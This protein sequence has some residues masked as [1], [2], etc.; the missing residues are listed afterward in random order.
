MRLY[1][2]DID[3]FD[4]KERSVIRLFCKDSKG[5]TVVALDYDFLPYF[6]VVPKKGKENKLA[7]MIRDIKSIRVH[8]IKAVSKKVDNDQKLLKASCFLASDVYK[9]RDIVKTWD[10]LVEGFFEYSISFYK[11][12]LIDKQIEGWIDVEGKKIDGKYDVD[13]TILLSKI[14]SVESAAKPKISMM[15]FDTEVVEDKGEQKLVMISLK[16]DD[17]EKVL[18]YGKAKSN[19][20]MEVLQSEESML[21]RFVEIVKEKNPDVLFGYNSDEFDFQVLRNSANKNPKMKLMLSRDNSRM[22]FSRRARI[23]TAKLTGRVHIDLFQFIRTVLSPQ[24]QT[25]VLTLDAV[26]S[27]ILSD[28]KMEM[29]YVDIEKTWKENAD[30]KKLASYCLKDS[31]LTLRLGKF[32][33]PQILQLARISGQSIFDASRMTYS[34]LVE[35]YLSKKAFAENMVIPNN[36]RW[37]EVQERRNF[38]PYIGGFV[39]EPTAGLHDNITVL[40]FRSLYPSVI[41]TFNISPETLNC[42][43]CKKSGF[44][45]P[46]RNYWFCK[47]RKGFVSSVIRELIEKR[48]RI[49]SS[50]NGNEISG[51]NNRQFAIKTI[52]NATYGY[53]GFAGSRWYCRECADAAAAF[54][55]F[56]IK[57]VIEDA[58]KQGLEIIYADT[59]S[60]FIKTS[61]DSKKVKV[62]LKKA[63]KELPGILRLDLQGFYKRGIFI[64]KGVGKGAAKK[65]Y[66]L[67]DEKG[68][69]TVRGLEKVRKDWSNVAKKTQENVLRQILEK[70]D[71]EAAKEYVRIVIKNLKDGKV[72]LKDMV[73][74]EQLS[75]PL[76]EY[77]A[78]GPHV[79]V[80]QK[81]I[82]RGRKI[83]EG[84]PIL[85]VITKGEGS[86][87]DR[88]EPL[89]DA[90]LKDID[91]D[92]YI[93]NQI[94]P[95][96]LRV[97]RVLG[98]T[99]EELLGKSLKDFLK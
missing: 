26:S 75:K 30:I 27:E 25:E 39:K 78:R 58:Q 29:D 64:P 66:A 3:Y 89:E 35:G 12:Y 1:L 74:I 49:K 34:Q 44:K 55:R 41:A 9:I 76:S 46:E 42:A 98:V 96:A 88:A 87:S 70:K 23:S 24:L 21:Q 62:F 19:G 15:A 32:I 60:M 83:R 33:M 95:S 5:K 4:E 38:S 8:D 86:I 20:F 69:L 11:R 2:L 6:Y 54:G 48:E 67:I 92:Y 71:V 82:E 79:A 65:R 17:F 94:V 45:V 40:D 47:K 72:P 68:V 22:R 16:S 73:I 52:A 63:N 31:E 61:K 57:K 43:C 14:K 7:K 18:T 13:K 53:F 10:E 93:S 91:I 80:A 51:S 50:M 36:P 90:K 85:F 37:N 56:Y 84:M 59:D 28:K 99:E 81:I 77:K 97:L